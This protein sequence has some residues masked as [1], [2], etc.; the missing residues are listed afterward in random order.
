[1]STKVRPATPREKFR[2]EQYTLAIEEE[3]MKAREKFGPFDNG[4]EGYAVILEELEELWEM[5]KS[6]PDHNIS[7]E[8]YR[9]CIQISAMAMA[10]A[11]ELL[12]FDVIARE[13]LK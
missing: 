8:M 1:M 3:Y 4:H 13:S 12:D 9:E 11:V 6:K 7:L 2:I 5:V 10:F